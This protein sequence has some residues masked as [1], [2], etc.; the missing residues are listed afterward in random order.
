MDEVTLTA[1][2]KVGP[3]DATLALINTTADNNHEPAVD[4]NTVQV[5]L[6]VPFSL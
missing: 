2:T 5:Y 1:S 3:V 4:G 6:T